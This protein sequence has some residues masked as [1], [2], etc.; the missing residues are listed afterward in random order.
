[1]DISEL[2]E[3]FDPARERV[4][5]PWQPIPNGRYLV[6][7]CRSELKPNRAGDGKNFELELRILQGEQAG[8]TFKVYLPVASSNRKAILWGRRLLA[9]LV[10]A[11]GLTRVPHSTADLHR[12]PF[13]VDLRV[14][15]I[16]AKT[17]RYGN[18]VTRWLTK[19]GHQVI[20]PGGEVSRSR[21]AAT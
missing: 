2:Y 19:D 13:Q 6:E 10:Y 12:M 21:K 17:S 1:M 15:E 8:N 4:L 14:V 18:Q 16:D 9:T 20:Q 11:C 5:S 3:N 7:I